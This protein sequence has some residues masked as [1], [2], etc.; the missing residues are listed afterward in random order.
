MLYD[1]DE[2]AGLGA[3]DQVALLSVLPEAALSKLARKVGSTGS[4]ELDDGS[5]SAKRQRAMR[6]RLSGRIRTMRR[7]KAIN[8]LGCAECG[9]ACGL[10]GVSGLG[11]GACASVPAGPQRQACR[12]ANQ[13]R[14]AGGAPPPPAPAGETPGQ[15]ITRLNTFKNNITLRVMSLMASR[16]DLRSR[17]PMNLW[18]MQ[19]TELPP[20]TLPTLRATVARLR[21]LEAWQ[22]AQGPAGSGVVSALPT[23]YTGPA[24]SAVNDEQAQ[25]LE[26]L[27]RQADIQRA[28]QGNIARAGELIA[29]NFANATAQGQGQTYAPQESYQERQQYQ[30]LLQPDVQY[31]DYEVPLFAE[32]RG[33]L[34]PGYEVSEYAYDAFGGGSGD[35]GY[36]SWGNSGTGDDGD[37]GGNEIAGLSGF[38]LKKLLKKVAPVLQVAAPIVGTVF[39]GPVGTIIGGMV[40]QLA[41]GAIAGGGNTQQTA[42]GGTVTTIAAGTPA[43]TQVAAAVAAAA[44]GTGRGACAHHTDAQAKANCQLM[45]AQARANAAGTRGGGSGGGN[46]GIL[47]AVGA[48][49]L[50][51][52]GRKR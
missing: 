16:P 20:G 35:E 50:F 18:Q 46:V 47:L 21:Q 33:E 34:A 26:N 39:G 45:M 23:L 36:D 29:A 12:A 38:S 31:D 14:R 13:A 40:G 41:A 3:A 9:G 48:V 15:E 27:R 28:R 10:G 37:W 1:V 19:P 30:E 17:V 5:G 4:L 22:T 51:A 25:R 11:A 6:S 7:A 42:D 43:A 32:E 8:G 24:P 52:M 44:A 49:A 2:L